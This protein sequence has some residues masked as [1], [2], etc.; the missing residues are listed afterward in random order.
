MRLGVAQ[1]LVL[2]LDR[3]VGEPEARRQQGVDLGITEGAHGLH[4]FQRADNPGGG[5]CIARKS[6]LSGG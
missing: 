5:F 3:G 1:G 6:D 2:D 4:A